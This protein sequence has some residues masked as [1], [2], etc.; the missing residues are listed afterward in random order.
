MEMFIVRI[1]GDFPNLNFLMIENKFSKQ[2]YHNNNTI[3]YGDILGL[4]SC[5]F[6]KI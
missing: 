3:K 6:I 5:I 1:S 2:G 4:A